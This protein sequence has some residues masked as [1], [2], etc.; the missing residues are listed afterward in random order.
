MWATPSAVRTPVVI[1]DADIEL[2][3]RPTKNRDP[4]RNGN[5][6]ADADAYGGGHA[7]GL[8]KLREFHREIRHKEQGKENNRG[9][10]GY[11]SI[12]L[13]DAQVTGDF[14]ISKVCAGR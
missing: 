3:L 9:Q 8:A 7:D 1:A 2:P 6:H 13:M 5:I 14:Q 11:V 10:P 4:H 12:L